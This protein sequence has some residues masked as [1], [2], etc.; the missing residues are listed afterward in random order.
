MTVLVTGAS[1]T[2]GG[3][4]VPRLSKEGHDVRRMSRRARPG[5]V[6]ADLATGAGLDEAVRG[7]DAIVHLATSATKTRETDIEGTRRLV[8]A[9]K[10]AGVRHMLYM[11]IIGIERAPVGY[12]KSKIAAENLIRGGGL[13]FTILRA[14]QFPQLVDSVLTA[15]S[16]LGPVI[17]DRSL[18]FQP[19]HVEDVAERIAELVAAG[20]SGDVVEFAGPEVLTLDV[21]ARQWVAARG[22]RRPVWSVRIPGKVAGA[23]RAGGLTTDVEP[24]G[25]RTWRNYLSDEYQRV[26]PLQRDH[27]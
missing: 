12:Y 21:L 19:V 1:G 6:A 27:L 25:T 2:L 3:A 20:P 9:A 8:A 26:E 7:V 5:W 17:I 16:K 13:P 15:T 10:T 23:V 24:R 14:A 4:V 18:V 22:R 11:S